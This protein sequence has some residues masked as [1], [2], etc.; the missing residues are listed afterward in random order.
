MQHCVV[1]GR[2]L[3]APILSCSVLMVHELIE[4]PL[5]DWTASSRLV[6]FA[7]P[8]TIELSVPQMM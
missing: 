6:T 7:V 8:I 1:P 5:F 4:F 2:F 3:S